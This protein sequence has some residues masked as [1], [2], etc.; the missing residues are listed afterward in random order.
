MLFRA[1]RAHAPAKRESMRQS[2][3]E[4][5]KRSSMRVSNLNIA[6]EI[7]GCLGLPILIVSRAPPPASSRK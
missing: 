6:V 4:A 7:Q 3:A 2:K 5:R 1:A